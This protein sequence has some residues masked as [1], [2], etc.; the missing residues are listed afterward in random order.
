MPHE[1]VLVSTFLEEDGVATVHH[2]MENDGKRGGEGRRCRR[3]RDTRVR[4]APPWW[5]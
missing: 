1:L 2:E 5:R 3:G 4:R